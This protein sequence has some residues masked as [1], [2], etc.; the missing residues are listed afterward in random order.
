[1]N[2]E[3]IIDAYRKGYREGRLG[4]DFKDHYNEIYGGEK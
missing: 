2:K 3:H 4:E 1:M